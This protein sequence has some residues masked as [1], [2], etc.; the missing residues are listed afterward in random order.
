ML[1]IRPIAETIPTPVDGG[2]SESVRRLCRLPEQELAARDIGETN[3]LVAQGLP[4]AEDLDIS[5]C[6]NKLDAWAN[7]VRLNTDHWWPNFLRSPDQYEDSPGKY[8]MVCLVTVVQRHLGVLYRLP[9]S[10]GEYDGTDSLDLF[11]H[12]VL[13]GHGGTCVTMPILY[14]AIGRRLGYPLKIVHAKEHTFVRWEE[15]N[16]ERFNIEATSEGFCSPDDSYYHTWPKP[17]T[18]DDLATGFYLRSL[19]PREELGDSLANRGTCLTENLLTCPAI[20]ALYFASLLCPDS[21]TNRGQWATAT[22]L[23]RMIEGSAERLSCTHADIVAMLRLKAYRNELCYDSLPFP[24]NPVGHVEQWARATAPVY[25]RRVLDNYVRKWRRG[26]VPPIVPGHRT[27]DKV[28]RADARQQI[29][30]AMG[31]AA[32]NSQ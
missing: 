3:L 21:P 14:A 1:Q 12:G 32:L 6:L 26:L 10:R 8:R 9:F 7:L 28:P 29:F 22:M 30:S 15:P 17:L 31:A 19:S 24:D 13:S 16:G 4:G 2:L 23:W 5:A 11:L 20:E 27:S 25:L 18:A